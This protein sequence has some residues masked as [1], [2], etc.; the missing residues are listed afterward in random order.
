MNP[1]K[2]CREAARSAGNLLRPKCAI[3]DGFAYLQTVYPDL[4][5]E[6]Y[7]NRGEGWL[8]PEKEV[9]ISIIIPAYNN[10][11]FLRESLDSV[12]NQKTRYS[13]EAVVI[14]DGSTDATPDILREYTGRIHAIRQ[15]NRGHSGA[16]NAGLAACRGRYILFHDSDDTL[17]PGAL[18]AL[19]SRAEKENADIVAGGYDC[20]EPGKDSYPGLRFPE[21]RA[22]DAQAIPGMT[23]GKLFRRS[24]WKNLCFPEGYWYEDSVICQILLPMAKEIFCISA[25]V[26]TYLLNPK[27]V[28]V[29][30]QGQKKAI[31]SLYITRRLLDEKERFGLPYDEQAYRH[32]LHMVLLT[33]HRTRL[34]DKAVFYAVFLGQRELRRGYF[35]QVPP[36]KSAEGLARALEMGSY[37]QYLWLCETMWIFGGG[38][39]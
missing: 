16:R 2:L 10:A 27:G 11:A 33:Y 31:E 14:D 9:D 20:R 35:A 26:F 3:S 25:P 7:V 4:G 36:P 29:S 18:E 17:C 8:T 32:F 12:L 5:G 19:M 23:C 22:C 1:R 37:R 13:F 38:R 15:E 21:G 34:L 6:S 24:M 28:S 30:S 39:V